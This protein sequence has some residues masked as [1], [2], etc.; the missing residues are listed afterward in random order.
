MKG[1]SDSH[2]TSILKAVS[3]R[4][5]CTVTTIL[6]VL[7]FTNKLTISLWVGLIEVI[8]KLI[9]YYI[10]ERVWQKMRR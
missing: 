1:D 10:H 4:I 7:F 9:L 2:Y 5:I 8:L 6:I 3:Y